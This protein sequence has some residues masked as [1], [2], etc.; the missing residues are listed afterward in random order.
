VFAREVATIRKL[1]DSRFDTRGRS[2][3]LVN[4]KRPDLP[5][6]ATVAHLAQVLEGI[7]KIIDRDEDIV[8][9]HITTHGSEQHQLVF[10]QGITRLADLEPPAFRQM[11]DVAGIKIAC[12]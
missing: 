5:A 3:Q 11:L 9:V 10:I 6:E 2:I 8:L 4:N 1:F 7:G 12:W